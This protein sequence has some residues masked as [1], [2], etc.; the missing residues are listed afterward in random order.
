MTRGLT[1]G[2]IFIPLDVRWPRTKKVRAMIVAHGLEGLA[3]WSLYLAMACYCREGLTD[4]FVPA[5]EVGA[6]AYPLPPEQA[7]GLLK[8]LL[9]YRLVA[10]SPGSSNGSS[11]GS[12]QGSSDGSSLGL[13]PGHSPGYI[14]RGYLKRNG[15]RTD[16][17]QLA[18]KLA[19]AGRRG[20]QISRSGATAS[21]G[22]GP[23]SS[24]GSGGGYKPVPTQTETETENPRARAPARP[25]EAG[26]TPHSAL[27]PQG[28]R[29]QPASRA[30]THPKAQQVLADTH[31]P[32]G[33]A[34][35]VHTWAAK[36]RAGI[37]SPE[38]PS[39]GDRQEPLPEHPPEPGHQD[40]P[41]PAAEPEEPA[42]DEIPF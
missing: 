17:E 26:W 20:G 38:D 5:A 7:D 18:A 28:G 30:P 2:I 19:E 12:S 1:T 9:D 11:Q 27:D 41:E 21:P 31:R 29:R 32:G 23:G 15:S 35:D 10:D 22:Y 40:P 33:P 4:G 24:P 14:V 16:A 39:P 8:L 36:A 37:T 25:R 6:L 42:E 13:S 3:A 34:Q